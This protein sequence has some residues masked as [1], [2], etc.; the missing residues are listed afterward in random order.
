[1]MLHSIG[2]RVVILG[3]R[4]PLLQGNDRALSSV[5]RLV[6]VVRHGDLFQRTFA[7][8]S[9]SANIPNNRESKTRSRD[10]DVGSANGNDNRS[11]F[12]G[13]INRRNLRR[14]D[15]M[16]NSNINESNTLAAISATDD[17]DW[18]DDDANNNNN[19][20]SEINHSDSYTSD[21]HDFS[22]EYD[23]RTEL[24]EWH[25]N[26]EEQMRFL[27][28]KVEQILSS[29]MVKEGGNDHI[30]SILAVM[31]E[32]TKFSSSITT[33]MHTLND[34]RRKNTHYPPSQFMIDLTVHTAE[35][36]EDLLTHLLIP[37]VSDGSSKRVHKSSTTLT[38]VQLHQL[39][40]EQEVQAYQVAMSAWANVYHSM[41][42]DRC[43][44]ILEQ[45]GQRF[46]GDMNYMPSVEA[47]KTVLVAHLNSCSSIPTTTTTTTPTTTT[48]TAVFEETTTNN[49]YGN[50]NMIGNSPGEKALD[51]LTLLR[52][53][54]TAGDIFLKPDI[55]LYTLTISVIRNTLLDWQLKRR[56]QS[57]KDL[58]RIEEKLTL[59]LL[60]SLG[61]METLLHETITKSSTTTTT[62][63]KDDETSRLTLQQ[64]HLVIGAY[65]DGLAIA[66]RIPVKND[67]HMFGGILKKFQKLIT[68]NSDTIV[69]S[70][71]EYY[72][73]TELDNDTD[74]EH[75]KLLESIQWNVE[76]ANTNALLS[77]L[78]LSKETA[79]FADFQSA[80]TNATISD[81]T[82]RRMRSRAQECADHPEKQFLFPTPTIETYR[83]LIMC[84][85][86]CVRK[87]YST[88]ESNNQLSTLAEL[89]HI[90]AATLLRELEVQL[91]GKPMEG[92]V[93]VDVIWAWGQVMSWP[94]IYK[95]HTDYFF[96]ANAAEG[97]LNRAMS[98]YANEVVYFHSFGTVTKMYNNVF[99]LYS[100]VFKSPDRLVQRSMKLLDEMEHW[101]RQSDGTI[102]QPDEF[103]FALL[104]KTVSNSGL[105]SSASTAEAIIQRMNDFGVMP[106]EKHYLG[107]IRAHSRVGQMDVS[108]PKKA[109]SIL[110]EVKEIYYKNKIVKPTSAMYSAVISAYGGSR[111]YNSVSKVMELFEEVKTLYDTTKD[112]DFKPDSLLYGAVI[113]AIAKSKTKNSA[114]LYQAIKLLDKM[115]HSQ[116]IGEIDTGPNKYA[117]TNL[118]TAINQTRMKDDGA[119]IAEELFQRM[120]SRSKRYNDESIRPDTQA[121]T[122]LIQTFAN[123]K[124]PDAVDRAQKWFQQ[125][126]TR[127]ADGD[128]KCKPNKVTCTALIN[129]WRRSERVEAGEEAENII[130]MMEQ[131]YEKG[132]LDMKPDAFVY[133]S[134]IDAWARSKASEK[135]TRAWNIYQRMKAQYSKG[136]LDSKPNN[137]IVSIIISQR[138]N[139][140]VFI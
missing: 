124:D 82:F 71:M 52:S 85:C 61:H 99:R 12:G 114:S 29:S 31:A 65:T 47:Y 127:A 119:A 128:T 7:S 98:Q 139:G 67:I 33:E 105:H 78:K 2:R 112:D 136:N 17:Q 138:L 3:R 107:L 39:T 93:Y 42:G 41:A 51:L 137:V 134:A 89:P 96:A 5:E 48:A 63:S 120:D 35:R 46:G 108:D 104:L 122:S 87:R 103:T 92:S 79:Y 75:Q 9:S 26:K 19:N 57:T 55:E 66:S 131:C 100:K 45:Y 34:F 60:D 21:Y 109:E 38:S 110:Q 121:Y 123:S 130:S 102:A 4:L 106:R 133:A 140:Y 14:V 97:I 113:D 28:T 18:L 81:D 64:W 117:Y 27:S 36:V 8:S 50:N 62:M 116:D 56:Y 129:C 94:G 43:E 111:E 84:W 44:D 101:Y 125:M 88:P 32:L 72:N 37:L 13:Y 24:Q 30:Q 95:N 76:A 49:Q 54:H 83:A 132:D 10:N 16:T 135:S 23:N 15:A 40:P 70:S 91:A 118:L 80:L 68:E 74:Q 90:K 73:S 11:D 53:V 1:M 25:T 20:N 69:Q 77:G 86:E 6:A 126:E 59:G 58:R 115:E 22:T